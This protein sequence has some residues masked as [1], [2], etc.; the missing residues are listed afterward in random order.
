LCGFWNNIVEKKKFIAA[1]THNNQM[2]G[3]AILDARLSDKDIHHKT[4][5]VRFAALLTSAAR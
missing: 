5:L 4:I 1:T 3:A 2:D